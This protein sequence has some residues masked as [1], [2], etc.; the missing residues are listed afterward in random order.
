MRER[1]VIQE[2][3]N[4]NE[5][6]TFC[7]AC[8]QETSGCREFHFNTLSQRCTLSSA[9]N[10]LPVMLWSA[11]RALWWMSVWLTLSTV[12]P[13]DCKYKN[14]AE[15]IL[16]HLADPR[17]C[18]MFMNEL[19]PDFGGGNYFIFQKNPQR[20]MRDAAVWEK[21]LFKYLWTSVS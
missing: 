6:I 20:E 13:E 12:P 1:S 14:E 2:V 4:I 19:G 9:V 11:Q 3:E 15:N 17:K 8:C 16:G 7:Q 10:I 21:I 5:T 18:Q